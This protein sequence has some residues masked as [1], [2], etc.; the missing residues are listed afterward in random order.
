MDIIDARAGK[1]DAHRRH[2]WKRGDANGKGKWRG[3][4]EECAMHLCHVSESLE[5]I[6]SALRASQ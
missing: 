1:R 5:E 3:R 4:V 2:S 6:A